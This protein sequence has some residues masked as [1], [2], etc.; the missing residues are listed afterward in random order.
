[1]FHA[2][3]GR[4]FVVRAPDAS[5]AGRSFADIAAERRQDPVECFL[6]LLGEHDTALRWRTVATNDR[7]G[8]LRYLLAHPSTLPGF[9]DSGAHSRNMAFQD[10]ALHALKEAQAHPEAM[11]VERAVHRLTAEP[12]DWLG[13]EAGRLA[14]GARADACVIDP[15]RLRTGLGPPIE[16]DDPRLDGSM[17]MVKRS[18]GV[19]R[20]VVIGGQVAFE[21]GAFSQDFGRARYGRLLRATLRP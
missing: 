15:E 20:I 10:G 8:P 5:L 18:E 2:D 19:V 4:M 6:D 9:N 13:I 1:V 14:P 17:R 21:E 3:F 16:L 11:T 7:P 12:A